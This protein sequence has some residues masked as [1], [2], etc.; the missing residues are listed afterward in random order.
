M[1]R[2]LEVSVVRSMRSSAARTNAVMLAAVV[3]EVWLHL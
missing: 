3:V 2:G 1:G